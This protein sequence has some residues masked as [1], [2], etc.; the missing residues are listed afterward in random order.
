MDGVSQALRVQALPLHPSLNTGATTTEY[1]LFRVQAARPSENTQALP[2]LCAVLL[3]DVSGSMQGAPLVQVKDSVERLVSILGDEDALG[4]VS[5]AT[6]A[7]TVTP[8]RALKGPTARRLLQQSIETLTSD[9]Y[10]N[11][12]AGLS[13]AALLFQP[14]AK[15]ERQIIL[16]LS[17]GQPNVGTQTAAG[18]SR[19]VELIKARG[20]AV[21]TLGYGAEHHEDI[22]LTI[23]DVGGGRYAFVK[24]PLMAAPSFARALGAQRDV[25]AE[26]VHLTLLPGP[27]V[28]INRVLG[29]ARTSF[30]EGGLRI[31]LSDLLLGEE[32]NVVVQL[33]VSSRRE[34]GRWR[35]LRTTLAARA[36]DDSGEPI[37]LRE[38]V[39][40]DLLPAS[41]ST[42]AEQVDTNV[43][44]VVT[45]AT[46]AE[47]RQQA[48]KLADQRNFVGAALCLKQ[49][50]DALLAVH[51]GVPA[52]GTPLRD[53]YETILD[54]LQVAEKAPA[55]AEYSVLR[56][57]QLDQQM[58]L[59]GF[60]RAG[61]GLTPSAQHMIIR[62][63][64]T[65]GAVPWA[66]LICIEGA[67]RGKSLQ[68]DAECRIGRG[69]DNDLVLAD[70]GATRH[71]TL[72]QWIG[73]GFVAH[74]LGSS[75]GT[76]VNG[77]NVVDDCLLKDGDILTIGHTRLRFERPTQP[78]PKKDDK[79]GPKQG[80]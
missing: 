34:A 23:A 52:D 13:H 64:N 45:M 67:D 73:R 29:E 15:N 9:G 21:S 60:N 61:A 68:I 37:L 66:R 74:D 12:S 30:G 77:R 20:I 39:S 56:K 55:P 48:R 63:R 53:V 75:N 14:R 19:E 44:E 47:L 24:D 6:S 40:V 80:P 78:P 38:D 46:A 59:T 36:P 69:A 32:V 10:T 62:L 5:F 22:L 4:I 71:H 51:G 11:I 31:S 2:R 65:H 70:R 79:K 43:Q 8:I 26:D 16:L 28:E 18:L 54:D 35:L 27:G 3:L 57:S 17:D 33:T 72:I 49:A 50:R 42:T 7:S 58:L 25:I 1:V 76:Y 41:A